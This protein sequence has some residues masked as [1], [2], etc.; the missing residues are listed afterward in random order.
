MDAAATQV[1][2]TQALFDRGGTQRTPNGARDGKPVFLYERN[3]HRCGGAGGSEAWRHTGWKCYECGGSG[4][5]SIGVSRLYTAEK[6]AKMNAAQ[7][8]RDEKRVAEREAAEVARAAEREARR[9][10]F[11]A[12]NA[13]FIEKINLCKGEFWERFSTDFHERMQDASPRQ[14]EIVD[15]EIARMA[16]RAASTHVG[17]IGQRLALRIITERQ[18]DITPDHQPYGSGR[19]FLFLARDEHGNR[20]VYKGS[21]DFP[22]EGETPMLYKVTVSEHTEYS[23]ESQTVVMRPKMVEETPS[24][25]VTVLRPGTNQP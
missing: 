3:C 16:A 4:R 13:G 18:I 21:G 10:T 11:Y 17:T 1:F 19:R 7:A 12:T 25:S 5:G 2:A 23:G 9:E 8:K 15:A 20:I 22:R 14:I 6:L 24:T